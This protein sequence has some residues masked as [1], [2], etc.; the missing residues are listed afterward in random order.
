MSLQTAQKTTVDIEWDDGA[1]IVFSFQGASGQV[2]C[3]FPH[4]VVALQNQTGTQTQVTATLQNVQ[5][6]A[7]QVSADPATWVET[8]KQGARGGKI[9]IEYDDQTNV[10]YT[11]FTNKI[12]TLQQLFS[13]AG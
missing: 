9:T 12:F 11:T 3:G 2:F 10:N 7:I 13:I 5:Q 1:V 6:S 8:V 4:S